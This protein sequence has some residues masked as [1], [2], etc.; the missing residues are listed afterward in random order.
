MRFAVGQA[1]QCTVDG[2]LA[3]I[4]EIRDERRAGRLCFVDREQRNGSSGRNSITRGM[5][6]NGHEQAA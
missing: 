5:A 1:F 3:V 6:G 2:R 4:E